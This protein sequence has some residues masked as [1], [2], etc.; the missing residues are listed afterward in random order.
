[1][2]PIDSQVLAHEPAV[3]L[4]AFAGVLALMATWEALSP[5]RSRT[6]SRRRRWPA[7]LGI[8]ALYFNFIFI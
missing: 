2:V 4:V 6:L 1:M 8:V 5:R 3:R 7:N